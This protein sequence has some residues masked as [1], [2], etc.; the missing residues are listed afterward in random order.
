M[1]YRSSS[2]NSK[3]FESINKISLNYGKNSFELFL[4]NKNMI[5]DGD[6]VEYH[7]LSQNYSTIG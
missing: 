1:L 3:E 7:R 2:K 6:L 4:T 5:L